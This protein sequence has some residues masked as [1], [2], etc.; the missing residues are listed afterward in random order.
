MEDIVLQQQ[1]STSINVRT[2]FEQLDDDKITMIHKL[3]AQ[4]LTIYLFCVC[5]TVDIEQVAE[6]AKQISTL[7]AREDEQKKRRQS[8]EEEAEK[9]RK[10]RRVAAARTI[11]G[12]TSIPQQQRILGL[13]NEIRKNSLFFLVGW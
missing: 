6:A 9:I 4:L 13:P 10:V 12:I 1:H 11:G 3:A 2:R 7:K 8:A 5:D